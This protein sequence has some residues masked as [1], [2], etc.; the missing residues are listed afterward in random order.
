MDIEENFKKFIPVLSQP[1]I[2]EFNSRN[3]PIEIKDSSQE[4]STKKK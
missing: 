1:F 4:S 2:V 3:K